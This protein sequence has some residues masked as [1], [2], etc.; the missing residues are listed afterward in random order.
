MSKFDPNNLPYVNPSTD[1]R[2]CIITGGNSGIGW[3]TVLHLYLHGFVVYI[4]GRS[5]NRVD[6]ATMEI[7]NEAMKRR[8]FYSK[9]ELNS[10]K[11]GELKFLQL[12]LCDLN[13][14]ETASITFKN[15]E[16]SLNLLINNAG[17]MALP[18][19]KTKDGFEIQ[20]QTNFI[21][22]FL[23][24]QR[25]IPLMEKKDVI[26]PRIIYL[27]SIGHRF[28][29]YPFNMDST[30]NFKPNILFTWFRYGMAKTAGIQ[31]MKMLSLKNPKILSV[32]VHPGF[33]MNTN[34]FSYWTRLPLIGIIF[35][36]FFQIFGFFFGVT[37][38]EG[39]YATLKCALSKEL[40]PETDNGKY[41][42]THGIE[43]NP[44]GVA[45]S[46][47]NAAATWLWTV[48]KLEELGYHIQEL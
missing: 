26:D 47:D 29:F 28:Q 45:S 33:V 2:V 41:Y 11:C 32:A 20:L 22:H 9:E 38:E 19:S 8:I 3:Y 1:R 35:W 7:K 17:V 14:V 31:Y 13:S 10:K 48:H 36:I 24:T 23:L 27:S 42:A 12:D 46:M 18:Y 5:K 6:K 39:A 34:L 30:F 21:S 44:S 40:T 4:G 25:L 43:T 16:S 37:N 15:Q